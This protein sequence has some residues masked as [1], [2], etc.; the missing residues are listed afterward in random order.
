MLKAVL[1]MAGQTSKKY[2]L[3]LD[4]FIIKALREK[5]IGYRELHRLVEEKYRR[6]SFETFNRHINHLKQS[7]LIDKDAKHALFY[8]TEKC[9]Q[10]LKFGILVLVPPKTPKQKK[11]ESIPSTQ[12]ASKQ[13]NVYVLL[14][15]FKSDSTYEFERVE[16]LEHFLSVMG[17]S[18]NS[19]AMKSPSGPLYKSKKNEVYRMEVFASDDGRITVNKKG[20]LSSTHRI[21]NSVSYVC[22][23]KCLKYP[24]TRYR[25]DPFRKMAITHD[26]IKNILLLLTDENILQKPI[27][28]S[29]DS[30]Y[31]ATD[32]RLY[33][34]LSDYSS[35]Y[36]ICRSTLTELWNLRPPTPEEIEWLQSIE[37][38][39]QVTRFIVKAKERKKK[40]AYY[41]R[42][43]LI[44]DLIDKIYEKESTMKE[45]IEKEYQN[46]LSNPRYQFI[47]REIEKF[48][49]P[50]WFQRIKKL[51]G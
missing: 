36:Y 47:I 24:V 9:K 7:I 49:F 48:A 11:I 15:L 2:D 45:S 22:N 16:E 14:L 32:I 30:I 12:L 23:V 18:M 19:F 25:S 43:K 34:L 26:E 33:D 41:K 10:Q 20:Y 27:L 50:D 6:L 31:L 37:G 46:T 44:T 42:Q 1:R 38:N 3:E 4:D 8:L 17:L 13:I 28:F 29:G 35:M 51:L 40:I 21:K 5:N 39:S